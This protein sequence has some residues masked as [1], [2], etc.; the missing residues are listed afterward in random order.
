MNTLG[1][2]DSIYNSDMVTNRIMYVP[3]AIESVTPL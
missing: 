3:S 1:M 2:I